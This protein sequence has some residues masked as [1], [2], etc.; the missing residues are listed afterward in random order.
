VKRETYEK[1]ATWTDWNSTPSP[2]SRRTRSAILQTRFL[3]T[4]DMLVIDFKITQNGFS[5]T[6]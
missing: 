5:G 6:C 2:A 1:G 4:S 3:I